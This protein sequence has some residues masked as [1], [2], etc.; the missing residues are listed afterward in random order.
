[1]LEIPSGRSH[2]FEGVGTI[3]AARRLLEYAWEKESPPLMRARRI[4]FRLLAEDEDPAFLF[5]LAP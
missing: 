4:L 1:M 2:G 5:E 3:S